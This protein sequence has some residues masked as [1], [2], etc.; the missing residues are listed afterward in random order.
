MELNNKGFEAEEIAV[1]GPFDTFFLYVNKQNVE[2]SPK[3]NKRLQNILC[4]EEYYMKDR[5]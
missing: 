2:D 4:I 3:N 5:L 1:V